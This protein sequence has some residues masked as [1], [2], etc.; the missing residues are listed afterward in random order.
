M[1]GRAPVEETFFAVVKSFDTNNA[2][3]ANF[4][5]IVK[6]SIVS[7]TVVG[8][9]NRVLSDGLTG[10]KVHPTQGVLTSD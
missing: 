2:I 7:Q 8:L 3:L 9:L 10:L 6:N 4:V 1:S 5:L